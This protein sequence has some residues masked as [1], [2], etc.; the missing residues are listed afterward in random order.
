M[1]PNAY[2]IFCIQMRD[3]FVNSELVSP[4]LHSGRGRL[5]QPIR[6][7][8][9]NTSKR[10]ARARPRAKSGRKFAIGQVFLVFIFAKILLKFY[11]TDPFQLIFALDNTKR[12]FF[13]QTLK[14]I[15]NFWNISL[16][17]IPSMVAPSLCH[18]NSIK[19]YP[20]SMG[21]KLQTGYRVAPSTRTDWTR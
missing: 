2:G 16:F 10:G 20:I 7:P 9:N 14:Q 3:R 15:S 19:N 11:I 12:V 4:R 8:R 5:L 17:G 18:I 21:T 13:P 1:P 6:D